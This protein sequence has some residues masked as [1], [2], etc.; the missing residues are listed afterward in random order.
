M[1]ELTRKWFA[2]DAI[3]EAEVVTASGAIHYNK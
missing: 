3:V 1:G 2:L